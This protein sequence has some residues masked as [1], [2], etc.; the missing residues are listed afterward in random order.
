MASAEWRV[1]VASGYSP[2]GLA[3]PLEALG[4][5]AFVAKP[6]QIAEIARALRDVIERP[7]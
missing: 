4:A 7:L 3:R 6:F 2:A 5:A 1:V